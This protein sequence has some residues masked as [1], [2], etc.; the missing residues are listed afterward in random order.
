MLITVGSIMAWAIPRITQMENDAQF[1][2]VYSNFEVFDSRADDVIYDGAGTT[3]TTGFAVGGGDLLLAKDNG[4][5]ILYWSLIEDNI[6]FSSVNSEDGSFSFIFDRM[7]GDNLTVNTTGSGGEARNRSVAGPAEHNYASDAVMGQVTPGFPLGDIQY[8]RIHNSTKDLAE[9]YYF[10]MKVV[11]HQLPTSDGYYEIKWMN[12][13]IVTNRG[14]KA[15][16][17]SD[18]PYVYPRGD[19]L[20]INI[21]DLSANRSGFINAGRGSYKITLRNLETTLLTS[22]QVYG[23]QMSLHT[24]YTAGWNT[25]FALH[26]DFDY[27]Y[28]AK[29]QKIGVSY[30][31]G[32]FT[33]LKLTKTDLELTG[34]T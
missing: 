7:D 21:I 1:D 31:Y 17:I 19:D 33:N 10:R 5:I 34:V 28:N 14:S 25:Y 20:Y 24:E 32:D 15:G 30:N 18:V 22:K 4:Y 27:L 6:T 16:S 2:G 29:Y 26:R 8:I 13:A 9:A 12:G 3:R 23:F 11:E